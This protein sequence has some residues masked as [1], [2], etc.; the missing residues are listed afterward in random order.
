M[1]LVLYSWLLPVGTSPWSFRL[2][3]Q[4]RYEAK[5]LCVMREQETDSFSRLY[6]LQLLNNFT[7]LHC[8]V[9]YNNRAAQKARTLHQ[10]IVMVSDPLISTDYWTSVQITQQDIEYLHSYLFDL[11]T[12]LT[13]RELVAVFI[14]ERIQSERLAVQKRREAGGKTYFPK[15]SFQIGDELI[16]PAL[17]WRHGRVTN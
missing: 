12:P 4:M 2:H 13:A 15:E 14:N 1:C 10:G 11:E 7:R 9:R 8:K 3:L 6:I 17:D 16:F 5:T